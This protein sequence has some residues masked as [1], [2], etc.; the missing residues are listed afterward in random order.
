[1]AEIGQVQTKTGDDESNEGRA[2]SRIDLLWHLRGM[3]SGGLGVFRS[4]VLIVHTKSA[5][6]LRDFSRLEAVKARLGRTGD[7]ESREVTKSWGKLA[8]ALMYMPHMRR[9]IASGHVEVWNHFPLGSRPRLDSKTPATEGRQQ[10]KC[11]SGCSARCWKR[12]SFV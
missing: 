2:V 12:I 5:G 3:L 4:H 6:L 8:R 9:G 7:G 1:M 11:S 10:R